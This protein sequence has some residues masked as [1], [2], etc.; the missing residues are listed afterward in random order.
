MVIRIAQ[1]HPPPTEA[2][3]V[4]GLMMPLLRDEAYIIL[5]MYVV[6]RFCKTYFSSAH[7]AITYNGSKALV[8]SQ[9]RT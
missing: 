4:K 9:Y 7:S 5:I 1:W 6:L 3:E 8:G 2:A